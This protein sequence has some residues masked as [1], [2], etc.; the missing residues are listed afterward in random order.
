[1]NTTKRIVRVSSFHPY[2]RIFGLHPYSRIFGAIPFLIV[3]SSILV[4]LT[5][6]M[7]L[8]LSFTLY[9]VKVDTPLLM[10]AFVLTFAVYNLDK[11]IMQKEDVIN[12]PDRLKFFM[13]RERTWI[14]ISVVSLTLSVVLGATEGLGVLLTLLLPLAVYA[15]YSIGLPF[16]PRLKEIPVVKN[17]V[18][19]ATWALVPTLLPNLSK[20]GPVGEKGMLLSILVFY[21]IFTKIMVNSILFDLRDVKGDGESGVRTLPVVLGVKRVRRLLLLLNSTLFLWI[22]VC[23][24]LGSFSQYLPIL[25]AST[26][27]G[28]WYIHFFTR[29]PGQKRILV[30]LLVDGEWIPLAL[31][32]ALVHVSSWSF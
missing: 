16:M 27:Y 2:S 6:S 1:M 20:L 8:L 13:G 22:T 31:V 5:S 11:V 24:L 26:L 12:D 32:I 15:G 3:S 4:S 30:D 10:A 7:V 9:G 28:F 29:E 21:F 18:L 17:V 23:W 19:V 14:V 25:A